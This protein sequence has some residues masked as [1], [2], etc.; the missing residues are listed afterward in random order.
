M[1]LK[2]Y[3]SGKEKFITPRAG[4]TTVKLDVENAEIKVDKGYYVAALNLTGK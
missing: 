1:P 4:F 3:V 2:I